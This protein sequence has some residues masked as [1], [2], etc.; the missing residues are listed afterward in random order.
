[1]VGSSSNIRQTRGGRALLQ[2]NRPRFVL[3]VHP[4]AGNLAMKVR[5][6][7]RAA[8]KRDQAVDLDTP[9]SDAGSEQADGVSTPA[10]RLP[11]VT[12]LAPLQLLQSHRRGSITDPKLHA[13]PNPP[14]LCPPGPI[15][16]DLHTGPLVSTFLRD[17]SEGSTRMATSAVAASS[18]S[19]AGAKS[20]NKRGLKQAEDAGEHFECFC[21]LPQREHAI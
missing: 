3:P 8:S 4:P 5:L 14:L 18:S 9:G 16:G 17:L 2:F 12:L 10:S 19:V 15:S 11:P 1:M 7:L 13:A 6:D 21:C 20:R